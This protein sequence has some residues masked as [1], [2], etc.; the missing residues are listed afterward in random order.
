M[1]RYYRMALC[2]GRHEIPQAVDGAIFPEI[3]DPTDL[4]GMAEHCRLRLKCC[5]A[6]DLYVTGLSV[7]LVTVINYCLEYKVKLR[8]WHFNA[9]TGVYYAQC[10]RTV[11]DWKEIPT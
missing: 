2:A 6:L 9:K 1:L 11:S 7:A 5:I 4:L 8:L 10:V 3:V